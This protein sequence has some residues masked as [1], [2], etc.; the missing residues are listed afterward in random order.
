MTN[1]GSRDKPVRLL[2]V[3]EDG[4]TRMGLA[5]L[6]ESAP[7]IEVVGQS[8]DLVTLDATIDAFRPEAI[9][10]VAGH[11]NDEV[12]TPTFADDAPPVLALRGERDA[13]DLLWSSGVRGVIPRNARAAQL[14]AAIVAVARGLV[15]SLPGE[16][17]RTDAQ[18][19]RGAQ[20]QVEA[21]TA[22]EF[23][24]LQLLAEGLA[25]KEIARRLALSENTV[26]FHVNA[27]LGKLGANS[28]TDAVVRATRAGLL[29]L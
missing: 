12:D 4:L 5:A 20:D 19:G 13:A 25:N 17:R 10:W 27:I 3:A 9:L 21:L 11:G 23:E 28:R 6:L 1:A 2:I 18:R 26:K 15:V 7:G 24:V 8:G 16:M 22:R 14:E 29:L